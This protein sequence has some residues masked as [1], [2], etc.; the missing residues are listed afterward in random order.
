MRSNLYHMIHG[1][2]MTTELAVIDNI[3]RELQQLNHNMELLL[4][5]IQLI[6]IKMKDCSTE[7]V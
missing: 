6:S 7:V 4:E 2:L 1:D 5:A 3:A